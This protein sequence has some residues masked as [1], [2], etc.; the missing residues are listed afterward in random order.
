M[1]TKKRT[2][3][4]SD[5]HFGHE[6]IVGYDEAPFD[7]IHEYNVELTER[8]NSRVGEKDEVFHLGDF[9]FRSSPEPYV[10][11]LNGRI[12][13]VLGNHDRIQMVLKCREHFASITEGI[14][15]TKRFGKRLVL[16]HYPILSWHWQGSGGLHLHGHVHV[17]NI[18]RDNALNVCAVMQ[19]WEPINMEEVEQRIKVQKE[20]LLP[21]Q[22]WTKDR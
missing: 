1:S 5:T 11:R 19:N 21:L 4:I 12:H 15:E 9:T 8:W 13:L 14:L 3:F 22:K 6:N 18:H 16:C 20:T 2:W 7:S 17:K 10:K